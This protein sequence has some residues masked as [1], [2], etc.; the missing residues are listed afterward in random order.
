MR[1]TNLIIPIL[2]LSAVGFSL[3][4]SAL[5]QRQLDPRAIITIPVT[6]NPRDSFSLPMPLA[7]L[8][9]TDYDPVFIPRHETLK[10]RG[11][12]VIYFRDIWEYEFSFVGGLRQ[13][14]LEVPDLDSQ[15]T[16]RQNVW[17]IIYRIRD[18]GNTLTYEKVKQNPEFEHLL[19]QMNRDRPVAPEKKIFLPRFFLEGSVMGNPDDGYQHVRYPD[20]TSPM[21]LRQIQRLHDP[22]LTLLDPLQMSQAEIPLAAT[23]ADGG[24]W[25]AAVFTNVDPRI[26]YVSLFVEGLTNAFR[27]TGEPGESNLRKTLQLNFWR[28]GGIIAEDKDRIT[29]GIPLV[30][31][32]QQQVLIA[33]RYNLPGP[34]IRVY[35]RRPDAG[36]RR[37]LIAEVD[38]QVDLNTFESPL[39]PVL[40]GGTLPAVVADALVN[41]GHDVDNAQ[42]SVAI[43]G[44]RWLLTNGDEEYIVAWE[45]QFWEPVTVR[46]KKQIRFI[47]ALD[48][49][50]IYR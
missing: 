41:A 49:L 40:D 34:L 16:R 35:Q 33:Q 46:N 23:D 43:E 48:N 39:L 4:D 14:V 6:L 42:L 18:R 27:I 11:R 3:A 25:G 9:A 28:P 8:N 30:D 7:G 2:F 47:K 36:E 44:K 24:V 45:P 20:I 19:E 10:N 29:Y 17:Y 22:G 1:Q 32:P 21:I 26:D 31:N 12:G 13:A 37:V 15:T 38:A 5:A 50:W